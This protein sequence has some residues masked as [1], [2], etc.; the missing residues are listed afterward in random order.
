MSF[1]E[2]TFFEMFGDPVRNEKGWGKKCID[3]FADT[4]LGKMR[5]KNLLQA[6]D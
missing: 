2:S 1:L 6:K 4:R 3:E 5:D